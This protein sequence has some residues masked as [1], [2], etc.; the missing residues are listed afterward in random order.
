MWSG[1]DKIPSQV[2]DILEEKR[3]Y[4]F[5]GGRGTVWGPM[6]SQDCR[7]PPP[8]HVAKQGP[9]T[10][11]QIPSWTSVLQRVAECAAALCGLE[12]GG[13]QWPGY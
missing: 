6:K 9:E 5:S 11:P 1:N 13:D 8:P 12:D 4:H 7:D 10:P 2:Q 3:T